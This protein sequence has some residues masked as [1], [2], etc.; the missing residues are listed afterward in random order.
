MT[1]RAHS[2]DLPATLRDAAWPATNEPGYAAQTS[3]LTGADAC[4]TIV[5]DWRDLADNASEPNPF[6]EPHMLLPAMTHLPGG[7]KVHVIAIHAS[8]HSNRLIGLVPVK[9]TNTYLGLPVRSAQSWKHIHCFLATPLLRKGHEQDALRGIIAALRARHIT[10]MRFAHSAAD[11]AFAAA[12]ATILN[13]KNHAQAETRRFE[14]AILQSTTSADDYIT[15]AISR[16]KRKEYGR[17]TRRLA[18][19]GSVTFEAVDVTDPAAVEGAALEFLALEQSGWKGRNGTAIA[20]RPAEQR[21]FLDACRVA[22]AHNTLNTLTLRVNNTAVASIINF[23][24]TAHRTAPDAGAGLFSFKIAYDEGF[25]RYSPGVLLELELTART[26]A[27]PSLAFADSCANPDHPMIDH[28]WRER[29]VMH[30][31]N[32]AVSPA[33]P[34][35]LLGAT[36][37]LEACLATAKTKARAMLAFAATAL[38]RRNS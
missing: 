16:K 34:A 7:S 19:E 23:T 30:D 24:G 36:R 25:A 14:R 38:R 32:I 31:I 27:D 15:A 8:P 26:L 33:T 4:Q 17:I 2:F 6:Y 18:D 29:R 22:A 3:W 20:Q 37:L 28:L 11:G 13:T 1:P 5:A 35:W 12:L 21:F 10:V 9:I